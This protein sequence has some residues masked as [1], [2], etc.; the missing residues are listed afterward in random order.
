MKSIKI[1][2]EET[3]FLIQQIEYLIEQ[4][5]EDTNWALEPDTKEYLSTINTIKSLR[6][7]LTKIGNS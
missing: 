7:I 3:K 1:N 6:N 2:Q 4:Y 5:E